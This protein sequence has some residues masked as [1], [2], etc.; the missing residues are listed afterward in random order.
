MILLRGLLL[1]VLADDIRLW[2]VFLI[3]FYLNGF[4][5]LHDIWLGTTQHICL[6]AM[7]IL[8]LLVHQSWLVC[9]LVLM[10]IYCSPM[11]VIHVNQIGRRSFFIISMNILIFQIYFDG[12]LSIWGI[13]SF[14]CI[15]CIIFRYNEWNILK[16]VKTIMVW[17]VVLAFAMWQLLILWS[18]LRLLL[19]W[20]VHLK[21]EFYVV[22]YQFI[23]VIKRSLI[24]DLWLILN[25]HL[26]RVLRVVVSCVILR[27]VVA[28]M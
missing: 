26:H 25:L 8:I 15:T 10:T 1:Q 27:V 13:C 20:L 9:W 24:P 22:L 12:L 7:Y 4:R 3:L 18:W 28:R 2:I 17:L 21:R 16:P 19:L 14:V 23:C 11:L 5:T 6:N